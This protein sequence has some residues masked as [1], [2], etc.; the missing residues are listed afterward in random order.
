MIIPP[1]YVRLESRYDEALHINHVGSGGKEARI[2]EISV[3][4]AVIGIEQRING[5]TVRY[6][7]WHEKDSTDFRV[8][9]RSAG[10]NEKFPEFEDPSFQIRKGSNRKLY[11]HLMAYIEGK[12][13]SENGKT[14]DNPLG[15]LLYE[16]EA[17]LQEG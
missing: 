5:A 17:E 12:P 15:R 8:Y 10:K 11:A 14:E 3:P 4:W 9:K 13:A 7:I 6:S 2:E 1:T 16:L